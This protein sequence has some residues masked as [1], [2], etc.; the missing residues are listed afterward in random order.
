[1]EERKADGRIER[2]VNCINATGMHVDGLPLITVPDKGAAGHIELSFRNEKENKSYRFEVL[3][4]FWKSKTL[5]L[6]L[7]D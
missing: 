7:I 3:N 2:V 5:E 6:R 4:D 1:M